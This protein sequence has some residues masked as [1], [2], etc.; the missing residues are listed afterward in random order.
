MKP[1]EYKIT[2]YVF[3]QGEE[4]LKGCL[5]KLC[6]WGK[7]GGKCTARLVGRHWGAGSGW[8]GEKRDGKHC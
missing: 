5:Y 1:P 3:R 2:L 8:S 7:M 6:K 4:V